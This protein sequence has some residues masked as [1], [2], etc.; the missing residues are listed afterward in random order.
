MAG[1]VVLANFGVW[2]VVEWR[3]LGNELRIA[4]IHDPTGAVSADDQSRSLPSDI[5]NFRS[6]E[7]CRWHVSEHLGR[8]RW[9]CGHNRLQSVWSKAVV[10]SPTTYV[11]Q[12]SG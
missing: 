5:L 2:P 8:R 12:L 10:R 6:C 3:C 7:T 9:Q 1:S 4:A 11:C